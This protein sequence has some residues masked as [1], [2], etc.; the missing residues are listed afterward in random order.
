MFQLYKN[1]Q[2]EFLGQ[3][4]LELFQFK[5][6]SLFWDTRYLVIIYSNIKCEGRQG[7]TVNSFGTARQKSAEGKMSSPPPTLIAS[8]LVPIHRNNW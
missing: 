3:I 4:F 7:R 8:S 6:R 5:S 1:I 2:T